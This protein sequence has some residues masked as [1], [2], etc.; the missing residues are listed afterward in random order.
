[1]QL[2]AARL[3]RQLVSAQE[4]IVAQGIQIIPEILWMA[5][6]S[7]NELAFHTEVPARNWA[8][9]AEHY[10][11]S[12]ELFRQVDRKLE[13]DNVELNLQTLFHLSGQPVDVERVKELTRLLEEAKDPRAD[14]GRNLLA[15][16]EG[17]D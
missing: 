11:R 9:A 14:K 7:H 6:G 3:Y 17:G 12:M 5:A 13:A 10:R 8:E 2:E 16:L 1:M 15:Q 4:K